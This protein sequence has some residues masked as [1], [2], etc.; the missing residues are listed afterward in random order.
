MGFNINDATQFQKLQASIDWS[1]WKLQPFR[2]KRMDALRQLVGSNYSDDGA[3]DKV[4][5]NLLELATNIY[6]RQLAANNPRVMIT[7]DNPDL[8]FRGIAFE[9]ALDDL[10][11]EID[12]QST[13][14]S[15][16]MDAMYT[17]GLVK[18]GLTMPAEDELHGFFH[19]GGQPFADPVDLSDWVHDM[20]AKRW[21]QIQYAG[22][23]Y[24]LPFEKAMDL[25]LFGRNAD[26]LQPTEE[27]SYNEQGDERTDTLSRGDDG[28]F[29]GQFKEI[30]ELWDI[31]LP[32]DNLVVTLNADRSNVGRPLRVVEWDG[33]EHGPFHR[34]GFSDV[35]NNIMPLAPMS[36]LMDLHLLANTLFR[37]MGRQAERQK[38]VTAYREAEDYRKLMETSDGEGYHSND[39]S[40]INTLKTG[41]VDATNLA[42]FLQNKDLFFSFG[43]NLDALG[44]LGPQSETLG[45]DELLR[46]AATNRLVDMQDRT[47]EAV[48]KLVEHLAW[49]EWTNPKRVRQLTRKVPNT[50][51]TH[52]IKWDRKTREGDFLQ[53]HFKIEPY[54][55]VSSTPGS[56]LQA[57]RQIFDAFVAPYAPLM[58]Q[59][60]IVP[61]FEELFTLIGKWGNLPELQKILKTGVTV[62]E[63][64]QGRKS[65]TQA[66]V[67][68]RNSVRTN[69]PGA[70][71]GGAEAALT[72]VLMGGDVNNGQANAISRPKGV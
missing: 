28:P 18:C 38:E 49:Y 13:L 37:K 17:M 36:V 8:E 56:K 4:P 22:N 24:T 39:P 66:P 60:G 68:T 63:V 52:S 7:P 71:R 55:M 29:D 32:D 44:G 23:R 57:L 16:V 50:E 45:Q 53:Y 15:W 14:R 30:I 9:I 31:W 70:T 42:F 41:G 72:Q 62:E 3:G 12:L 34:L 6:V 10:F 33:P 1:R 65:A 27:R 46:S 11:I 54:S 43:G 61:D 51:V 25:K 59:S 67:T 2:E 35:P 21:D 26:D 58:Q 64:E 20:T 5:V 19:D 69:R 40:S 48:K 47:S